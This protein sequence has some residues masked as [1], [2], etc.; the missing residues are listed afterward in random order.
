MVVPSSNTVAEDEARRLLPADGSVTM[1]VSR[2]RVVQISEAATSVGQFAVDRMVA[3][4]ELLADAEVDLILWNGT[5]AGWLGFEHD[6]HVVDGI[7]ART[8]IPATTATLAMNDALAR[9]RAK[10]IG[11]VTPYAADLETRIVANYRDLG[12]EVVASARRDLTQNTEYAAVSRETILAM[13]RDVAAARPDAIVVLC[14]NLAGARLV[15]AASQELGLFVLDS[16]RVAI[17]HSLARLAEASQ[18]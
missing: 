16:V 6:R 8:G 4:A 2:V 13:I 9:L 15:D 5:A 7:E 3:A 12:V 14:T 18:D 10:R 11:L 1:H 17:E